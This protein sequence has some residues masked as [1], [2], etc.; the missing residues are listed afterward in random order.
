MKVFKKEALGTL[1]EIR[2]SWNTHQKD[3]DECFASI[4]RFEQTYSRFIEGNLLSKLNSEWG[5]K[6]NNELY[7]LIRLA[8]TI[9]DSTNDYFDI[10]LLPL[11][12]NAGYGIGKKYLEENIWSNNIELSEDE[13]ILHNGVQIDLWALGKWY[14]LDVIYGILDTKYASFVLNFW[15]DIKVKCPEIVGLEDPLRAWRVIWELQLEN[16]AFCSSSW[17]KRKLQKHHHIINP[18]TKKSPDD[19][20][21]VYT[22]HKLW[23]FADAYSTALFVCPLKESLEILEKTQ[24][25]EGLIISKEGEIFSSQGFNK[26][27]TLY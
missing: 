18:K 14:M 5:G 11:L 8:K 24:W 4:E 22:T 16:S 15:G 6:I 9:S 2:V 27:L 7:S 26:Y 25:L 23:I 21:I 13:I 1:L 12:E 17:E 20:I 19:K 10:T 3:I